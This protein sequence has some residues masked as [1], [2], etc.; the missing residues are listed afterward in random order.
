MILITS[1][2]RKWEPTYSF[3]PAKIGYRP[4]YEAGQRCPG[5]H[6]RA[7]IVGRTAAECHGC[8]TALPL[9]PTERRAEGRWG[10]GHD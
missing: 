1:R 3:D 5:C 8:G 6:G 4:L 7:W 10:D 9:A 2:S